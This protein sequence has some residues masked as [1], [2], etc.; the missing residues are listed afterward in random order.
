MN[1]KK[2]NEINKLQNTSTCPL[3]T[4]SNTFT[5]TS[6]NDTFD[7]GL[8]TSSLQTLNS[9]DKLDGGAGTEAASAKGV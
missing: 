4:G 3:T 2:V 1:Q 8:T 5:G 6:G 7:G 9:G